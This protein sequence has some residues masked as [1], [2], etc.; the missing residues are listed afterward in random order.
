MNS[1]PSFPS[2]E[3][4][5][6]VEE[7][8]KKKADYRPLLDLYGRIFIAQEESKPSL[9]LD[10]FRIPEEI[11]SVKKRGNFPLVEVS[12]FRV[13]GRAFG[14]LFHEISG[15]LLQAGGELSEYV[16]KILAMIETGQEG[17]SELLAALLAGNESLFDRLEDEFQVDKKM[18]GFLLYNSAKPSLSLFS[19]KISVYRD[20]EVPWE[21]G[22]C[23]VCGSMPEMSIFE[24]DGKRSLQC[25]FCGHT[26]TSR[27]VYCPYCEN[28]DH[29][30][31][32]YYTIEDEEEYRVD[33][34]NKCKTYIKT[35]DLRSVSRTVYLPL[36]IVS[37]PYMNIKF[38]EMGYKPGLATLVP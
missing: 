8:T 34:C 19:M 16:K 29:E 38:E 35:I 30:T 27:R 17:M 37:T 10:E 14:A 7:I 23:P 21:K 11:L 4:R 20:G 12:Q 1:S 33:V 15:I 18:L 2:D 32:R 5:N 28:T 22:Y 6:A 25:G 26:W 3:I 36:E 24:K 9:R 31:L 13:D